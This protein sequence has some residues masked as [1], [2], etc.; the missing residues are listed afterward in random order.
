MTGHVA[1]RAHGV[2]AASPRGTLELIADPSVFDPRLTWPDG[3][4]PKPGTLVAQRYRLGD[5]IGEGGMS[6]VF[7]ARDERLGR[8]VALKLLNPQRAFS[9]EIVTRFVNE[10][11]TLAQLDCPHV[12]RVFDAGVTD[13]PGKPTLPFMV[14]ELLHGIELRS[15]LAEVDGGDV[16]R[17]V[18]WMLQ[19]CD[20]LAAA[21]V[22]GIIHRDLK[23]ANLFV[24]DEPDGTQIVK[25][26]DFGIARSM[27]VTPALT[28]DGE[29][30]GSPGYM[31]PE[32]IKDVRNVDQRSDIWSL[33]VVMYE[34][35]TGVAPFQAETPLDLCLQILHAPV[36]P[37]RRLRPDLSPGLAA[38]IQ[39]CMQRPVAARFANVAEL[40]EALSPYAHPRDLEVAARVRRRLNSR[41]PTV[42]RP[43]TRVPTTGTPNAVASAAPTEPAQ[44]VVLREATASKFSLVALVQQRVPADRGR[45]RR[46]LAVGVGAIVGVLVAFTLA[47]SPHATTRSHALMVVAEMRLAAAAQ[48]LLAK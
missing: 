42:N 4:L 23:P 18:G 31:S 36:E 41:L 48:G 46:R 24:V 37:L 1:T 17:V 38:V 35:F 39:R 11:R 15:L 13:E 30:M 14:L 8:D 5:G 22:E 28:F 2:L 32:Q 34:I 45:L 12:V 29:H 33:G 20:G 40:A 6:V 27:E 21:H 47:R 19:I 26:L 44:N 43:C 16:R 25:V 3:M 9:P 10:A 7:S